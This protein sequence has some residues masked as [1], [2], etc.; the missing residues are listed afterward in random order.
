M[1]GLLLGLL[2]ANIA[3]AGLALALKADVVE[4]RHM[5]VRAG[6]ILESKVQLVSEVDLGQ[7][8]EYP[9]DPVLA[10]ADQLIA[11]KDQAVVIPP[12]SYCVQL[13]PFESVADVSD[14]IA[15][16][17][18]SM[19]TAL[20]VRQ[21]AAKPQYRVYLP[22][23]ENREAAI[24]AI[25]QLRATLGANNLVID[26]FL[27]PQGDLANGIALGLFAEQTNAVNV[28]LQLETVGYDAL[29]QEVGSVREELDV[30]IGELESEAIF[31]GYWG[32]IQ[33]ARPYLRAVEKLCET[34]AQGI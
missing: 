17:G 21:Q 31:Q 4:E 25:G 28:K 7:L 19:K 13:G 26:S 1:R 32:E 10:G 30:V 23:L 14:F 6:A 34:I 24:E 8:L 18:V 22:P 2:L 11:Q 12:S 9:R 20:D 29:I 15:V 5:P 33:R 27:I 3:Y 16:Y